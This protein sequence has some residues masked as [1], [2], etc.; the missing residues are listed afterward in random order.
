MGGNSCYHSGGTFLVV[1]EY[2]SG[3]QQPLAIGHEGNRGLDSRAET[4][5]V[6]GYTQLSKAIRKDESGVQVTFKGVAHR[7]VVAVETTVSHETTVDLVHVMPATRRVEPYRF[8]AVEFCQRLAIGT[9]AQKLGVHC[10]VIIAMA[11]G[12][13]DYHR[14][15]MDG[16]TVV[17]RPV[18]GF[19][20]ALI[21]EPGVEYPDIVEAGQQGKVVFRIDRDYGYKDVLAKCGQCESG[22]RGKRILQRCVE[23]D[24]AVATKTTFQ[25]PLII[26]RDEERPAVLRGNQLV[27]V[28]MRGQL[29]DSA[30]TEHQLFAVNVALARKTL[31]QATISIESP[32]AHGEA[33]TGGQPAKAKKL[34]VVWILDQLRWRESLVGEVV[35]EAGEGG[36]GYSFFVQLPDKAAIVVVS[37]PVSICGSIVKPRI[38]MARANVGANR[39][40]QGVMALYVAVA[41]FSVTHIHRRRLQCIGDT[42]C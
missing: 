16:Q 6:G 34:F 25:L 36:L 32:L 22:S 40:V 30:S 7:S 17:I 14:R 33:I 41:A 26:E 9:Q 23:I 27:S 29:Q 38:D 39:T 11:T 10:Y 8:A 28:R 3:D 21:C 37:R 5:H 1:S 4:I 18:L 20:D 24:K 35:V 2:S 13:G 42:C 15:L 19:E 12:Q 31:I